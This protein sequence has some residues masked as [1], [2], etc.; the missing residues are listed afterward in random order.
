MKNVHDTERVKASESSSKSLSFY[1]LYNYVGIHH[2][3]CYV[4]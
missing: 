4:K 2:R 3:V 1:L